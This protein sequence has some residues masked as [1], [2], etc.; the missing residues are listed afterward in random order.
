M[1]LEQRSTELDADVNEERTMSLAKRLQEARK[2]AGLTL[3]QLAAA[4]GVSKTYLW[5][6]ENDEGGVKKPSAE[7]LLRIAVPLNTT[8]ADLLNQPVVR[9]RRANV[10]VSNSLLE[11]RDF[12]Q[13]IGEPLTEDEFADLATMRFRGGQPKSRDDW[14]DLYRTLRRTTRR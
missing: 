2:E 7:V 12:M 13:Q 9:V 3:E 6:L 8:I 10:S 14:H 5:E 11:F 1:A 4:S